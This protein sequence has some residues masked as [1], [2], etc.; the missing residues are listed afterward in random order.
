MKSHIFNPFDPTSMSVFLC[1]FE[2]GC[3]TNIIHVGA[4]I[5]LFNF[6]EKS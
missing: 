5:T 6:F 3:D 2:L 1:S 4:A